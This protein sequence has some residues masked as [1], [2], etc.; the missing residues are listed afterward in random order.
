M[1][2]ASVQNLA[3]SFEPFLAAVRRSSNA[4]ISEKVCR[5][6]ITVESLIEFQRLINALLTLKTGIQ[7]THH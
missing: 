3:V 5:E 2:R 7:S 1:S 4:L 6:N